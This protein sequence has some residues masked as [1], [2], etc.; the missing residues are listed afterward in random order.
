MK[1]LYE[2]P[3]DTHCPKCGAVYARCQCKWKP[4]VNLF[5]SIITCY[6]NIY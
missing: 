4:L 1:N 5:R 3:I 2:W 6:Q